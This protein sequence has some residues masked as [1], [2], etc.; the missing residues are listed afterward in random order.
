[1]SFSV[2]FNIYNKN[3]RKVREKCLDNNV[4]VNSLMNV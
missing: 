3:G 4:D 1:M 2:I